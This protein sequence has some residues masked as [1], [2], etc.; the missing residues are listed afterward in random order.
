MSVPTPVKHLHF[1]SYVGYAPLRDQ[2]LLALRASDAA[3]RR[4]VVDS[5]TPNE[6]L[7]AGRAN[8]VN[9]DAMI[10]RS[11]FAMEG[12]ED[13]TFESVDT[14]SVRDFMALGLLGSLLRKPD[15][16]RETNHWTPLQVASLLECFVNGDL[17]PSV[18]LWKSTS[19]I[20]VI[21][22][23]HRLSALKAWIT[24]DYGDGP[25]SVRL[26]GNGISTAQKRAAEKTRKLV[27]SSVGSWQHFKQRLDDETLAPAE[28]RRVN[29]VATRALPIQWVKGDADRAES[30]FFKINTKGTPLDAIEEL[31]LMNRRKPVS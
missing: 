15:F 28:R 1:A 22:G 11:D 20:F 3:H 17:I 26:F 24:D 16:Q 8:V 4:H 29:T 5:P 19:H 14:I 31:L 10:V 23:G 25:N 2:R 7:M 13:S 9:L 18:I 30:S 27:S 21:D 12:D 6:I